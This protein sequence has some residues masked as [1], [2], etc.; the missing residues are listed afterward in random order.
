M[1]KFIVLTYHR[2]P[3]IAHPWCN[4]PPEMFKRHMDILRNGGFRVLSMKDF[5]R[6]V[7]V[8]RNPQYL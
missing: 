8:G 5:H 2:V 1:Q 3:D 6:L 4:T 7:H